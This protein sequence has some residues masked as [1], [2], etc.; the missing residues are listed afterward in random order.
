MSTFEEIQAGNNDPVK[1]APFF[2]VGSGRSGST[3]LRMMFLSHSRLTIPPETWY[4]IPLV[5]QFNTDRPLDAKEVEAAVAIITS[6]YRWPDMKMDEGEFRR[7]VSQLRQPRVRDLVE[8]VYQKH[9]RA[10]G[11]VRWGD[12]TPPYIEILP[13][14]AR[15]YPHSRFIHLYRDGRDVAKSFQETG[16]CGTFW[17][18]LTHEW[19]TSLDY[20]QRWEHTEFR[21]RILD[22]RYERLVLETEATL[23]EICRFIGE[24]FEPQMLAWEA[25]VDAQVPKREQVHHK[26]LKKRIS[27]DA[28]ARWKHELSARAVFVC[29]ALIG[30]YLTRWGYERRYPSPLWTPALV[31]MRV[32]LPVIEFHIRA[33]RYLGRRLGPMAKAL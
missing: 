2:I 23:R 10:E 22:V 13:E 11:K 33:V 20:R 17:S 6:H 26:K 29:E 32:A 27:S 15:M 1:A 21:D 12:K 30:S 31:L 18:Q 4:L 14:L 3:L 25:K 7:E 28:V 5:K 8:V 24:E 9:L 19:I 16:W